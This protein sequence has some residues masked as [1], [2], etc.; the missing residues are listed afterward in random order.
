[1]KAQ[2]G[3][4]LE[5]IFIIGLPFLKGQDKLDAPVYTVVDAED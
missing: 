2:G 4:T 1:V 5:Y 3:T